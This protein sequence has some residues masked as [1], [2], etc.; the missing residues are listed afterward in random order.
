M[1]ADTLNHDAVA[2]LNVSRIAADTLNRIAEVTKAKS[3]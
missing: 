2:V 1:K 3:D